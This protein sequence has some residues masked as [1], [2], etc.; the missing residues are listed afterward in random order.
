MEGRAYRAYRALVLKYDVLRLPP[1]IQQKIPA[2]L[3]IQAEFQAWASEWAKSGGRMPIPQERPLRYLAQKFILAYSALKW[4]RGRVIRRGTRPPLVLD[5]QLR[6]GSERDA[7]RG[8]LVDIPRRELR[9]RRLGV[10]TI[11]LPLGEGAIRWIL[12]RAREGA[13]LVL[14]MV[15]VEGGKLHVALVFRREVEPVEPKRI[16]AVDLNALHNGIAYAVVERGR[17]LER[18]A[19]RPDVSRILHAQKRA[20]GLDSP[21]ARRGGPYCERARA[22]RSRIY[23]LLREWEGEAARFIIKLALQYRA[24]I[25][26]DAPN[27]ESVRGLK[28]SDKYPAERKALLNFGKLRRGLR[29]LAEWHGVPCIEAR[30]FSTICPLCGAKMAELP[31]RRVKCARCGL[32]ARRDEVPAMWAARRFDELIRLAS[33]RAFSSP[34]CLLTRGPAAFMEGRPPPGEGSRPAPPPRR[35]AAPKSR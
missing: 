10:G 28:E 24:A 2:L 13:R 31:E 1:E 6:L 11:A 23:R 14:A 27:D 20:A 16:L 35:T 12:A 22:A 5:A 19:L 8:A 9:V 32:T 17:I 30:L 34:E 18:S 29:E 25:V 7:S 15:W 21:C 4:L 33:P 3:K 26:V